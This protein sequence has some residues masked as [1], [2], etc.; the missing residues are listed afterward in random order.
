MGDTERPRYVPASL[1]FGL[2]PAPV[3]THAGRSL[4]GLVTVAAFRGARFDPFDG[5]GAAATEGTSI[6]VRATLLTFT[7]EDFG[8]GAGA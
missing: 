4:N 7:G 3:P 2:T 6:T 1:P 8:F 5:A